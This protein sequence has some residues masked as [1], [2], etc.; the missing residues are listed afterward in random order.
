MLP[1]FSEINDSE[2]GNI[3]LGKRLSPERQENEAHFKGTSLQKLV[4]PNLA[5]HI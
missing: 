3:K 2:S 4:Q 1:S 5:R